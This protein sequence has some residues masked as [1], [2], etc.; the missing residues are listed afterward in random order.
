M[1][2]A[3]SYGDRRIQYSVASNPKLKER[4]RIHVHPNGLVE[5]ESPVGKSAAAVAEAVHKRARW[6]DSHLEHFEKLRAH[7]LP[8][9]YVS[10]ETHFYLGRR[11]HLKPI[12]VERGTS[13]VKLKGGQ[14]QV[15][16][17]CPDPKAV[18]R[19][20]GRWYKQRAQEYLNARLKAVAEKIPW[21]KGLPPLKLVKMKTQWGSCSP[22]G[23]IFLNPMLIKAPRECIDYVI[24]HEL[25]H[26]QEHNH[27]KRFY[28][29]LQREMPTWKHVKAKLDGMGELLL[30]E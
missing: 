15:L 26:L 10:G 18:K 12:E 30:T 17:P 22:T 29:L 16:L 11:Y 2:F 19:R 3:F 23:S 28:A 14:I 9:H 4:V 24:V 6:I 13:D 27:S 25:C 21:I 5:V 7:A 8:R 1:N 20:L